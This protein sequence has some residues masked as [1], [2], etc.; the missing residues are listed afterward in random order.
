MEQIKE[1]KIHKKEAKEKVG[2]EKDY[3][4]MKR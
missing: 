3:I 1:V 4:A 2:R